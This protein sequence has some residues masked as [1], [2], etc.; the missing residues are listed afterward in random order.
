VWLRNKHYLECNLLDRKL[1]YK[2]N[3]QERIEKIMLKKNKKKSFF[4]FT[5]LARVL[6]KWWTKERKGY[7][8]EREIKFVERMCQLLVLQVEEEKCFEKGIGLGKLLNRGYC[9]RETSKWNKNGRDTPYCPL[10][11]YV[12]IGSREMCACISPNCLGTSLCQFQHTSPCY[13]ITSLSFNHFYFNQY[14]L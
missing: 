12:P 10:C 1:L 9:V 14:K 11:I 13:L 2:V 8:Y 7:S 3:I 5:F 6:D 4:F